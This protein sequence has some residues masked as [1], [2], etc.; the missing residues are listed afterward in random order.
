MTKTTVKYQK[1]YRGAMR[2]SMLAPIKSSSLQK[3]IVGSNELNEANIKQTKKN[4]I[5]KSTN[6]LFAA[7]GSSLNTFN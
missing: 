4:I 6:I 7:S 1:T 5:K 2:G 3:H